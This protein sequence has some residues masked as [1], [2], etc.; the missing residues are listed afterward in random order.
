MRRPSAPCEALP[1][2]G[3]DYASEVRL[4]ATS[5]DGTTERACYFAAVCTQKRKSQ[6][7]GGVWCESEGGAAV[8]VDL[9][10]AVGRVGNGIDGYHVVLAHED[11]WLRVHGP[12][13]GEDDIVGNVGCRMDGR[14]VLGGQE[15]EVAELRWTGDVRYSVC[16]TSA[17]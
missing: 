15:D 6:M 2:L 17:A 9:E 11:P 12:V 16:S 10:W 5:A 13:L 8:V 14:A 7:R 1:L 4:V 3:A